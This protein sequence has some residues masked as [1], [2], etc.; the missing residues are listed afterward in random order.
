M[1][2]LSRKEFKDAVFQRDTYKCLVCKEPAVDAH[3]IIERKLF[4]D[5]GYY[6]D[7]GSSLCEVHHFQ[8]EQTIISCNTLR[9]LA[10]IKMIILPADFNSE[11]EYDKWG[12]IILKSGSRKPGPLFHQESVQKILES[13]NLLNLFLNSI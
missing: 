2:L 1:K 11:L 12:N 4:D 7:N 5:G 8:A 13:A 3:H 6:I 9:Q 10:K